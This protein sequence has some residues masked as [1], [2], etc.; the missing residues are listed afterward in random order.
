MIKF[1]LAS[2]TLLIAL[3]CLMISPFELMSQHRHGDSSSEPYIVFQRI[4]AAVEN[5]FISKDEAILQKLYAGVNT[6]LM[7]ERFRS[8]YAEPIKCLTPVI[9][10][11]EQSKES[12]DPAIVE[13][14][15]QLFEPTVSQ[16]SQTH[17]SPSGRF[18]IRYSL[19]GPNAVPSEG[20]DENGV[21]DYVVRTAFAADSSYSYMVE[22]LGFRDFL[23]NSP[24]E[25]SY[26]NF[27]GTYGITLSSGST[28][29]MVVNNNFDGFPPNLHP[30]GDQIGALYVTIAH[31]LKHA[32]Q[33]EINRF[34]NRYDTG[35]FDWIEMDA[36]LMEH[37]VFRDVRDYYNYIM[38]YDNDKDDWNRN[39]PHPL[40]IFGSPG[41]ATP[42]AYNHVTWMI[43]FY[44]L[45]G[46]QFWVDV[47]N[48]IDQAFLN[49]VAGGDP[50]T[51]L[52]A[53]DLV[54]SRYNT[55]VES[56]HLR[57]HMWHMSSGPEFADY[58]F[59]FMDRENYP[60]AF[61]MEPVQVTTEER[62]VISNQL[63]L[64]SFAARYHDLIPIPPSVALGQP[65]FILDSDSN[66]L[67]LGVVG[68]F[69]DG[70]VQRFVSQDPNSTIQNIQTTW[71]W[72]DLVDLNVTV[73][74]TSNTQSGS[75]SLEIIS[76]T[77]EN[78]L[79]AQNYP[80]PFNPV[81]RIDFALNET[82]DVRLEVYDI[83]GRKVATL[84]DERLNV[85]FHSVSFDGSGL[86]SG[87]YLYRI[88]TDQAVLSKKMLL[89]K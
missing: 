37:V 66:G 19:T 76:A 1:R 4:E 16:T 83:L 31:E 80:N 69:K 26:R 50:I 25:I 71:S 60:V 27:S 57:N 58:D 38:R 18:Q 7:D 89:V 78:D 68:Y 17:I 74:N 61:K 22:T 52:E 44:E 54:L 5:G 84:V 67:Y 39:D 48:E 43:Y 85:G 8:D 40:S 59:G 86:A 47:W 41:S 30:E 34:D 24:Y 51:F 36:T 9:M 53:M 88:I 65:S 29:R 87:V 13:E 2:A 79:I 72:P 14:I 70:S 32:S 15:K 20:F 12:M 82:K 28:T 23:K 77:P 10:E 73:V 56:E 11:F 81:T 49:R 21:P 45:Y 33:F 6:D 46:A 64:R 3:A 42:G 35:S 63:P 55:S 75:Y 62:T